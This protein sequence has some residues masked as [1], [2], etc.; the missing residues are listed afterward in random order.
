MSKVD[1]TCTDDVTHT[2]E[3]LKGASNYTNEFCLNHTHLFCE[4]LKHCSSGQV[5]DARELLCTQVRQNIC[6]AEWRILEVNGWSEELIDCQK[7]GETSRPNCTKQFDLA[8]DNSVCLPLCK[9]FSQYGPSFTKFLVGLSAIA[10]LMNLLGGI[11]VIIACILNRA[12]MYN[13]ITMAIHI[14][15]YILGNFQ[16]VDLQT[17][18]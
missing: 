7:F 5:A 12:K 8:N 14:C 11:I 6:T 1:S 9:E 17:Y 18:F 10:H 4:A 13:H 15:R 2:F 3:S 16:I